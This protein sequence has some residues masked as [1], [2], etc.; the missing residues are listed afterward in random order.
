[1]DARRYINI[2]GN[3]GAYS[4]FELDADW[5][6]DCYEQSDLFVDC[7]WRYLINDR[8]IVCLVEDA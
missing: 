7:Y 3:K 8:P 5:E 2:S 1:M 6:H 4:V